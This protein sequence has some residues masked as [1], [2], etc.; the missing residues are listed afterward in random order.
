M[1]VTATTTTKSKSSGN[2]ETS[3][4]SEQAEIIKSRQEMIAEAAYHLAEKRG[5]LPGY[6][7]QDWFEAERVIQN[8]FPQV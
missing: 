6:E 1:S 8:Q 2:R 7:Q 4:K 5:F 3:T